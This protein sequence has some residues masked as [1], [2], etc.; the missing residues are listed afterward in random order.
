MRSTSVTFTQD[1][2]A[3]GPFVDFD[4]EV[5]IFDYTTTAGIGTIL[6]S[7]TVLIRNTT[8]GQYYT[9]NL[10]DIHDHKQNDYIELHI[11]NKGT[12]TGILVTDMNLLVTS[13]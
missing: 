1:A 7:S 6:K 13:V 9:V 3:S 11:R 8:Y 12:D 4:V 5:G 10:T 2:P